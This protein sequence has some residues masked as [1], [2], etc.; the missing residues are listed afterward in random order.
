M[1][2]QAEDETGAGAHVM[3]P[4]TPL[5]RTLTH[6]GITI[7][8]LGGDVP[9]CRHTLIAYTAPPGFAGVQPHTH[10]ETTEWFY[11]LEGILAWSIG[12]REGRGGPGTH[13]EVPPGTRHVWRNGA[14]DGP[15]RMLVGFDRPGFDMYFR[16]LI[17]MAAAAPEWPPRDPTRWIEL[18]RQYDTFA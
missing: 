18:G 8:V 4:S 7:T 13:V 12:D 10:R 11:V 16:K 3:S 17:A 6:R 9:G 14:D 2:I 15:L 5:E 1:H